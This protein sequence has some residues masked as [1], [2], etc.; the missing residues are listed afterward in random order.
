MDVQAGIY[1]ALA[2]LL[3]YPDGDFRHRLARCRELLGRREGDAD[4]SPVVPTGNDSRP[5]FWPV[6]SG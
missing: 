6:L 5:L 1:T 2:G 4:Q 3:A